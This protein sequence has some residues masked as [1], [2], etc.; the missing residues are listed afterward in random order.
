MT[1]PQTLSCKLLQTTVNA[2]DR[3]TRTQN[4]AADTRLRHGA[5]LTITHGPAKPLGSSKC[6]P[7][8]NAAP[9]AAVE[10]TVEPTASQPN[11][12]DEF[13]RAQRRSSAESRRTLYLS[14]ESRREVVKYRAGSVREGEA[15]ISPRGKPLTTAS[16]LSELPLRCGRA[17]HGRAPAE[18]G[19]TM[20][21]LGSAR[22]ASMPTDSQ[23]SRARRARPKIGHFHAPSLPSAM[24]R[25]SRPL[26]TTLKVKVVSR[27]S[28]V[29]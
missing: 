19:A 27:A 29:S 6:T 9:C 12:V 24:D 16:C 15:H 23:R 18:S 25:H 14:T 5:T 28:K 21:P 10:P 22:S 13:R 20:L 4:T 7:Y 2:V 17:Q 11:Q 26:C 8:Q 1:V 3:G